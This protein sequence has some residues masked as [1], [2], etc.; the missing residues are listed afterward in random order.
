M[1]SITVHGARENNLKDVDVE[2]PRDELVVVTG[3]SGSGKSSLAF[4]TLYAEG[5]RRYVESLSAYARQ[6]LGQMEKPDVDRIEGLSPAI[7][8]DQKS[9]SHNPRSTVGTVTEV[10]DYMRVLYANLGTPHCPEC[11]KVVAGQSAEE[12]VEQIL[13]ADEGARLQVLAPVVRHRK[14]TYEQ[15]FEDLLDD[16]YVRVRV[17]GRMGRLE[18][19]W[20]LE[21]YENHTIEVVVDRLQVKEEAG[22]RLTDAVET[23]LDLAEG[24]VT[25]LEEQEDVDPDEAWTDDRDR[26]WVAESHSEH[27]ACED[28]EIS[29]PELAPKSFS[30]NSPHGACPE[31]DG[32]GFNMEVDPELI[33]TDPEETVFDG[34]FHTVV[35]KTLRW[36]YRELEAHGDA[37]DV[38]FDQPWEDLPDAAREFVL[39]GSDRSHNVTYEM[40]SGRRWSGWEAFDG[41]LPMLEDR[42][43]ETESNRVQK[44]LQKLMAERDCRACDGTRLREEWRSVT[45]HGETIDTLVQTPIDRL[46]RWFLDLPDTLDEREMHIARDVLKEIRNRLKFMVEVG[47]EYLTLHRPARTLSGGESQRIRLATQIGSGLTGVLY[48]LDEPT[49]GLHPRDNERLIDSLKGLRDHGN[50]LVVVEHDEEMIRAA[51]HVVD[52][53]PGAGE[54]GGQVVA[55]GPPHRIE[56]HTESLTGAYLAGEERIPVPET[57]REGSGDTLAVRGAREHNLDDVDVEIPLGTFTCVTGVSGSGK[58]TLV[59]DILYKSLARTFHDASEASGDHDAVEG[60]ENIEKVVIIDQSPIGRTPRSNAATY[61]GVFTPVRE[62]F[63]STPEAETRGYDKGRFSFNVKGGRCEACKGDGMKQIEMHFL[64]DVY[65]PCEV[66]DGARYN[67]ETLE[68]TFKGK[69]IKDVLDMTVSEAHEFFENHNRIRRRLETLEDVGLGYLKLGQPAPTLS[70]GEA[71]RVKLA[72]QLGKR[73]RGDTL[74]ILDEPTTGLHFDDVRKLLDTLHRLVDKDNTVLIIE[75]NPEV[76]KSADHLV[77]L[78]P[79][80]GEKGGRV[81]AEGTPEEVVE[82]GTHTGDYLAPHLDAAEPP[83]EADAEAVEVSAGGVAE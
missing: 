31:C 3:L 16:G 36:I 11:G 23:A 44:R 13:D 12:I 77:D 2:I 71:Q 15:L 24:H 18:D 9:P 59:N 76:V 82:A 61:T 75:H 50:T 33:I 7:S 37:L 34:A 57:R 65:V 74:Y 62:L 48:I 1:Q 28:C 5:Q 67:S 17:D 29:L 6:F 39:Y 49:I 53:G 43:K 38:D 80:G 4:E 63:A 45:V 14:G 40:D 51:D 64:A 69:T 21:R 22:A 73:L 83:G 56:G 46:Y 60:T 35:P 42:Y 19:E 72:E 30:F 68:V 55:E 66:C 25:V 26:T 32:L 20:G 78:G 81:V 27:F 8:I 10:Y 54:E 52:L 41:V 70:G 58:S 47:L 79:E